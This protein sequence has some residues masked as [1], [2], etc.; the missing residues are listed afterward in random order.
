MM[1]KNGSVI[2][3]PGYSSRWRGCPPLVA[4]ALRVRSSVAGDAVMLCL[5]LFNGVPVIPRWPV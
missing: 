4:S 3:D 1:N 5:A 2:P